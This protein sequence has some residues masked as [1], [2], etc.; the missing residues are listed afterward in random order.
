MQL[1]PHS[2]EPELVTLMGSVV[3][4]AWEE[5]Q[6]RL[7][8][9]TAADPTELRNLVAVRVMAAVANGLK[10]PER[11]KAIALEALDA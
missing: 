3:D 7:S 4:E 9:P 5:A 11:L 6:C 10:D 8:F 1:P 2:F